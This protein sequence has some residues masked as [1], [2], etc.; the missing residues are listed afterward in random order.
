MLRSWS[1]H[2]LVSLQSAIRL[3]SRS[4]HSRKVLS[5]LEAANLSAHYMCY[6]KYVWF[7]VKLLFIDALPRYVVTIKHNRIYHK[8]PNNHIYH[9]RLKIRLLGSYVRHR[10]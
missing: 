5:R 7:L 10:L 1:V 4:L 8:I 3:A 9:L 6:V 2:S